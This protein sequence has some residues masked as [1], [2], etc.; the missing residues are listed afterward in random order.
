M[1]CVLLVDDEPQLLRA[2]SINLR[3]RQWQ[4]CTARTGREALLVAAA[5][6]DGDLARI[7]KA[8]TEG[9]LGVSELEAAEAAGI[10]SLDGDRLSFRHPLMRA[11]AYHDASRADRRSAHRAL[12]GTLLALFPDKWRLQAIERL[13]PHLR[14]HS[15]VAGVE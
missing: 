10:V 12:A 9:G 4:V 7:V 6:P 5:E 3:A 15:L 2:L 14:L 11:A 13:N 1:T 8:L